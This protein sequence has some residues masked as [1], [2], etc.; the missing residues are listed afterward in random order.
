MENTHI[1][2]ILPTLLHQ[3]LFYM[4]GLSCLEGHLYKVKTC[5]RRPNARNPKYHFWY[6]LTCIRQA[7]ALNK[8]CFLSLECLCKRGVPILNHHIY[9]L[10]I[11]AAG[12]DFD[13]V[14]TLS[15]SIV[16][17][18]KVPGVRARCLGFNTLSDHFVSPSADSRRAV[19]SS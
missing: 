2:R 10:Q 4:D 8:Q 7:Y 13:V 17:P 11:Y 18:L 12:S 19:L 14:F 9:Y 1:C 3:R 5:H 15:V 16:F 6:K